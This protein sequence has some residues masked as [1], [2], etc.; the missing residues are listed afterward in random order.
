MKPQI[1]ALLI[2][3]DDNCRSQVAETLKALQGEVRLINASDLQGGMKL[4]QG[5][6]LDIII[7]EVKDLQR[8]CGEIQ[9]LHSRAPQ[10]AVFVSCSERSPDWI[11]PLIRAGAS[12][13]LTRPVF[14]SELLDAV[15]KIA[16]QKLAKGGSSGHRGEVVSLYNPSGGMGTTTIAV[17]L[18]ATLAAQGQSVA[19]V[20]LNLVS[21]DVSAFLDLAPRYTLA[22]ILAKAGQVDASII[23]SIMASHPCGLQVLDGLAHPAEAA[24]IQ[25]EFLQ[26]VIPVLRTLFDY[27]V[28]DTGGQLFG[29]NLATFQ[30]SDR[31]L[32]AMVLNLPAL[33][34]AKRYLT[35]LDA[36]GV[37]LDK[38]KL[39]VNRHFPKDDIKLPDAEKVLG[40]KA[41]HT[42]PNTYSD[43]R[44]SVL[45]GAPLVQ[46]NPKSP[47]SKAIEQLARQLGQARHGAGLPAPQERPT[48]H[49]WITQ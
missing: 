26:E 19:L 34:N 25:P 21:P 27:T 13:Y 36:E 47:F 45:K 28:I 5:N 44:N 16:K 46:C 35:A 43:V 48:W 7:L 40:T 24:R 3:S 30:L 29:C 2:D 23:K 12:E 49:S 33:K 32:Y 14:A 11:L 10:S 39:V 41:Y 1:T 20:D 17:N 6:H 9:F 22:S 8:G 37:G 42:L 38:V 31:V 18:A 4:L 15:S